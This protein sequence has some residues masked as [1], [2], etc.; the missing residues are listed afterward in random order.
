MSN[1]LNKIAYV[2][3]AIGFATLACIFEDIVCGIIAFFF[4]MLL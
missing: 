4:L 1:G 3:G 2:I